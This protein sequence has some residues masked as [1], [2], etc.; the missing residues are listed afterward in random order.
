LS[1]IE[2]VD[3]F[4]LL[5][6]TA[7]IAIHTAPFAGN[8]FSDNDIWRFISIII[9]QLTRFAVPFFFV[10]SGYFWGVKIN[11]GESVTSTSILMAKKIFYIFIAWSIVYVLPSLNTIAEYGFPGAIYSFYWNLTHLIINKPLTI[12]MEGTAPHLWFL[13]ALIYSI[14]ISAILVEKKRFKTLIA[15]SIV[16]YLVVLISK[17]YSGTPF[18]I[19]TDFNTRNGPFIGTIF[20]VT[21][22]FLSKLTPSPRWLLRGIMLFSVGYFLHLSES[23]I[24]WKIYGAYPVQEYVIGTYFMGVGAAVASL[25][26]NAFLRNTIL[27]SI[28]KYT[29]GIY[30]I[31]LIFVRLLRPISEFTN[32]PL[33][34][35]G[36][37]ILVLL[38]SVIFVL[39]LSRSKITRRFVI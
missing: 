23:Y 36:Y 37:I 1:R 4:R 5:A 20:F 34:E 33:W 35:I 18:G 3:V 25:S 22:Y 12:A 30:A 7:V 28:G 31:H 39:I 10:I 11:K 6:I 14:G 19:Q 15:L 27:K 13:V 8:S 38:F 32:S 2:S 16:L 26:N 29:L 21:G 17:S 24:L 9:N